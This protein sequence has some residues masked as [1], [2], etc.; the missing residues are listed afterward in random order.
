MDGLDQLWADLLSADA[1]RVERAWISLPANE[2][3]AVLDHLA[4]M[5]DDDGWH[6][7]QRESATAALRVLHACF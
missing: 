2:R 6:P 3:Q 5:R 4:H 1:A 7:A